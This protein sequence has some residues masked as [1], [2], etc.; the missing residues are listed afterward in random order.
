MVDAGHGGED[1]GAIGNGMREKDFVLKVARQ[2]QALAPDNIRLTRDDDTFL[3]LRQRADI[4]NRA[5][6][7]L[8]VSIHANSADSNARG[9][10]VFHNPGSRAGAKLAES[11]YSSCLPILQPESNHRGVK[12][13]GFAVLRYTA[14][15]AILVEC[16]FISNPEAARWLQWPGT[17][18]LFAKAIAAGLGLQRQ[19]PDG[20]MAA[21]NREISDELTLI[22]KQLQA[23][24]KKLEK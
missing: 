8:F 18:A 7:D 4:A 22:S 21:S 9:F 20:P 6:A 15:P 14:M 24:A 3:G 17:P 10:E 2:L 12:E 23:I 11:V 16:E 19:E 13:R 1:P 5:D